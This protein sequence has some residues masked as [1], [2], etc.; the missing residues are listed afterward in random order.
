[1]NDTINT[2][3]PQ[4]SKLAAF[5]QAIY[6]CFLKA[7]DVLF[8][9]VDAL[10]L[11]PRLA[12]FPELSCVPVF[13]RRWPSLYEGLEDGKVDETKLL[14][15]LTEQ[16]PESERPLLVGDHTAWPRLRARTLEDRAF[17]HQPT[18]IQGQKPITLGHGYSTLGVVPAAAKTDP[19]KADPT[20]STG[21]WF[22][23]RL[24]RTHRERY[25][26]FPKGGRA[27]EA[28]LPET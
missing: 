21:S 8:E 7:G 28:A 23:P 20:R 6:T 27:T 17:Q 18:P 15:T 11:S 13:R 2:T 24:A 9:I 25:D 3:Q 16:L 14:E 1:M 12:S 10:L 26:A 22:L 19:Q 5:R 4:L